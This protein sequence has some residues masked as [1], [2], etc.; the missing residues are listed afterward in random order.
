MADGVAEKAP[1]SDIVDVSEG[2]VLMDKDEAH[3]ASLG[4]KQGESD[5]DT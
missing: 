4:Y 5:H 1:P 3:L 2:N